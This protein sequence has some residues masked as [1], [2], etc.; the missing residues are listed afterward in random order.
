M[1]HD[2]DNV[3]LLDRSAVAAAVEESSLSRPCVYRSVLDHLEI[4]AR[5]PKFVLMA[6][7]RRRRRLTLNDDGL[8]QDTL[9]RG[10]IDPA[11]ES[12]LDGLDEGSHVSLIREAP[13][14]KQRQDDDVVSRG[15]DVV[16]SGNVG[17]RHLLYRR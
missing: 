1:E 16:H 12:A 7:W 17:P 10:A 5:A 13:W 3:Y 15:L 4:G 14:P 11:S 8:P 2:C 6:H 9:P